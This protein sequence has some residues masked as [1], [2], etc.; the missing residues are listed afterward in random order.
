V[1][2]AIMLKRIANTN[3]GLEIDASDF[4]RMSLNISEAVSI[5]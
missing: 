3:S 5:V 1:I 4:G 2:K